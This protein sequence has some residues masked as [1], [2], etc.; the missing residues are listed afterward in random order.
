M[1]KKTAIVTGIVILISSVISASILGRAIERFRSEE[2]YISVRGFSEREVRADLAVWALR[3]SV[4]SDDLLEASRLIESATSKAIQF[5]TQNAIS[6]DEIIQKD[7][8]VNDR[9]TNE[10]SPAGAAKTLRYIVTKT[11][12]VRSTNVDN[13]QKVSRMT[14]E[15]LR[16]GVVIS[17]S[18]E[19]QG[20]GVRFMFTK[21][22]EV[23]PAMLAEATRNA[24]DAGLEFAKESN[25]TLGKMKKASQGL[26]TIVDRDEVS[27]GQPEGGYHGAGTSDLIK[28]VRVVISVE[29]SI[30]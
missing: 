5:L 29:Y 17:S 10:Y 25:T 22:N 26:F 18:N 20:A 30:E 9:K 8:Q 21:L 7:L 11:I 3:L 1:D 27:A 13:V 16:A 19:W 12:Q 4:A 24:K 14:D 23:K 6:S 2:R 15:L 28:K